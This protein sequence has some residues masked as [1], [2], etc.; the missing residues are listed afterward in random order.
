[1]ELPDIAKKY[2]GHVVEGDFEAAAECFSPDVFYSHEAYDPGTDGP[3][4]RRMEARGRAELVRMLNM[5]GP[6]RWKHHMRVDTVGDRFFIEG[7]MTDE[8][9]APVFSFVSVGTLTSDGLIQSYIEYDA[10]P[11]VGNW[12]SPPSRT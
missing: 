6:R 7:T 9:D 12:P 2:F 10:R 1:M 4:G 11:P 5:R 8:D 3:T